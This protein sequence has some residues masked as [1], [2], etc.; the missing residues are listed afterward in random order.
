[1][2]RRLTLE[3]CE[4][5][6]REPF[7]IAR[8]SQDMQPTLLV[9]IAD[10]DGHH[11]RGEACGVDYDGETVATMSDQVEALRPAIEA[12]LSREELQ[13]RLPAGGARNAVDCALWDLKSRQS[14]RSLFDDVAFPQP[15]AFTIGMRSLEGY[16]AAARERADYPLLKVKVGS[17]N[18]IS[19]I[20][21]V[22][23]GAPNPELIVDPN[24]AWSVEELKAFA[25]SLSQ[26]GVVLIEQPIPVGDEQALAGWRS[27][28]PLCADELVGTRADLPRVVG[29]FDCIN[30]KLD[31][32][33]GLTEAL[34]LA[35][36]AR[37]LGLRVMA[38]CMAGSSLCMA[39]S[40]VLAPHCSFL[41]LDGP[42]LQAGDV[43]PA[44]EYRSG[45]IARPA[46]GLWGSAS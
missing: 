5:Q 44:L 10:E 32:T 35:Q 23:R 38:G 7:V 20:E 43:T 22:R 37:A 21:A 4:W 6:L 16:E 25:P 30:I 34:L 24:Q 45:W 15:T 13:H 3:P 18:P 36:D 9:T 28:V 19:S 11:G 1:M 26:L 8:G 41:D 17:S 29:L 31:K 33:G 27:P 2:A 12:G 42:L 46:I 14:R 39:P 40:L